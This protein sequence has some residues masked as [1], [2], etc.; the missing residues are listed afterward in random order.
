MTAEALPP[1][2]PGRLDL[3]WESLQ[4]ALAKRDRLSDAERRLGVV[5]T[6][7]VVDLAIEPQLLE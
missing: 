6:A 5:P 2:E 3:A 1:P 4:Q 7:Q